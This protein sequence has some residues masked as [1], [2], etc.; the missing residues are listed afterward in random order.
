MLLPVDLREWVP[1]DDI[2]HFVIESVDGMVLSSLR[3]NRRGSGSEQYPP[4]MMLALLIYCYA[5]GVF[6]SR[7]IERA[8]WRDIA[9]R[10]L[11][12]DTHP[13]HDTIC[14]FRRE[15]RAAIEEAFV[16]V[17]QLA[18]RMG[19]L[20]VGTVSVDGTHIQANASKTRTIRY[21]R[22]GEVE[23]QLHAEVTDLLKKAEESDQQDSDDGQ[24]LPEQIAQRE[25]LR[26]KMRQARA[27][28]EAQ[29]QVRAQAERAEYQRKVEACAERAA[30][31]Q[32]GGRRPPHVPTPP[33]EAVP[34]AGDSINLT[35]PDSR[36]MR[37]SAV[38][39]YQQAYN[40]QA[41]V[42]A[43]GSMLVL[44]AHVV[45]ASADFGQLEVGVDKIDASL[46]KAQAVLADGAYAK[47]ASIHTLE[48]RGVDVYVAITRQ[49]N[50]P[51]RRHD[52]RSRDTTGKPERSISNPILRR[53]RGKM[54]REESQMMYRRRRQTIE[55]VFGIIKSVMGFRHFL[56]RGLQQVTGEWSLVT[57]AYN[58]KRL[59]RLRPRIAV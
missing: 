22:A 17:L 26:D 52:F 24:R 39:G 44:A 45:Q 12:G 59:W 23:E 53:M 2:V 31:H 51:A 49:Q 3:V 50:R 42:D 20:K 37:K 48:Q 4:K 18:R 1:A 57:L 21:D 7:R 19:V 56:L 11:T 15:N 43:D 16:A 36:T 28:L 8:T 35:D 33:E 55:P 41:V 32:R 6:S 25:K 10:Y 27:E 13:D 14:K 46:G 40:A 5:L 9:V 54:E 29:A 34:E 58:F 47:S 38:D 30:R